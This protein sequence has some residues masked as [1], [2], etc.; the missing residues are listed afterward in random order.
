MFHKKC[1]CTAL[2]LLSI[3]GLWGSAQAAEVD[4]DSSYCFSAGDFSQGELKGV[5]ITGLPSSDAG[6]IMLGARVVRTGDIL[7]AQQLNQLTFHPLRRE[8]DTDVTVTYLPIYENKVDKSTTMTICIRGKVDKAPVAQDSAVETYKNLPNT[9]R[10]KVYDPEGDEMAFTLTRA[11]KRGDVTLHEDGSFTYTPKKNKVGTDSFTYTATDPAGNVS[12]EAT[13]TIQI[14]KPGDQK[15][16][17][18]TLGCDC[19]FAAEWLKNTGIFTGEMVSGQLCFRP[20]QT[21]TRGE[22]VA[23]LVQSLGIDV[24]ENAIYTGFTD[25]IPTWLKPYLAA[26]LRTGITA[27]W[28]GGSVFGS[29]KP[30]TG[31]EA[32]LLLQNAL[33]L[34]V[35]TIASSNHL[36]TALAV[37]AENGLQLSADQPMTRGEVAQALYQAKQLA[38]IAPGMQVLLR[39]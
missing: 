10:L 22:F 28:P 38:V 36:E 13:V 16:Y 11:P 19:R 12:R 31:A 2:V 17:S 18:D 33:A 37:M 3:A 23:M 27:G 9:G 39:Q 30:I 35:T 4:C 26:A 32:A 21:V 6:T 1:L 7:T 15:P 24:D 14:L 25:E 34:P 5:C 29:Q 8:T 20:E